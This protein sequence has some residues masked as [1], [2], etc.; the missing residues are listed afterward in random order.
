MIAIA[1]QTTFG[2]I[3]WCAVP[4]DSH[5]FRLLW[6]PTSF[7]TSIFTIVGLITCIVQL[8]GVGVASTW[9]TSEF[10]ALETRQLGLVLI[11]T[12]IVMQLAVLGV[13]SI[14]VARFLFISPRWIG[15]PRLF[16]RR[17]G[18]SWRRL[19]CAVG[20]SAIALTVC[21]THVI[22]RFFQILTSLYLYCIPH[23]RSA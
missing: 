13:F 21:G 3:V 4:A 22:F 16:A 1:C 8:T 7:M 17:H 11:Q 6:C 12:G 10:S 15:K 20:V 18:A 2:R 14:I 23:S 19:C 5:N 9:Y